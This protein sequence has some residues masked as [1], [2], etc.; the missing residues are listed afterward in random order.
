MVS[1]RRPRRSD[2]VLRL[3]KLSL[4]NFI[5]DIRDLLEKPETQDSFKKVPF[6]YSFYERLQLT[7]ILEAFFSFFGR[8]WNSCRFSIY[9]FLFKKSRPGRN[10]TT[11]RFRPGCPI[12]SQW[13]NLYKGPRIGFS[14]VK[15]DNAVITPRFRQLEPSIGI[16]S[17]VQ[18]LSMGQEFLF[19]RNIWL[20]CCFIR[21][22]RPQARWVIEGSIRDWLGKWSR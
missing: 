10:S 18:T 6:S 8:R 7:C 14:I 2:R 12:F 4:E 11:H 16:F 17:T 5:I 9:K 19:S 15:Q 13:R 21:P 3:S 1:K 22:M 20:M